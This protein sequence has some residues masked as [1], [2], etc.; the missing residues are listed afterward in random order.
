M[1]SPPAFTDQS[2]KQLSAPNFTDATHSLKLA[3]ASLPCF[4]ATSYSVM[5]GDTGM[6]H[7]LQQPRQDAPGAA[8]ATVVFPTLPRCADSLFCNFPSPAYTSIQL[9]VTFTASPPT[10]TVLLLLLN[11]LCQELLGP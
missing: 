4:S 5:R 3:G 9:H 1:N 11:T 6:K 8:T 10:P 7:Q 2:K